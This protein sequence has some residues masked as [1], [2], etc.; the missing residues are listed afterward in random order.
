[1]YSDKEKILL[2]SNMYPSTKYPHYGIFVQ[3]T[4]EVL[5][6][7]GMTVDVVAM[8]KQD[9]AVKKLLAYL[10]FYSSVIYRG[11]I[12]KY[13]TVYAHYASHT[14]LPLLILS[15]LKTVKIVVNVHGNDVVSQCKKDEKFLFLVQ[16]LL[17]KA[18]AVICPSAYFQE[19][20]EREFSVPKGNTLVYPSGGVNTDLFRKIPKSQ[21]AQHFGLNET[22]QYIG[23]VSRIEE[24]KGWDIFLKM[25]AQLRQE[26]P[27]IKFLVVGDGDQAAN[28]HQL[29]QS[30][31]LTDAIIKFNLLSQQELAY[32]YNLLDVFVFPT[33]RKS[34]SLGLVG[35]EAM[36]CE[37]V[38]VL[39]DSYGPASY[40]RDGENAFV[41]KAGD[42]HSLYDAV[43]RALQG[44]HPDIRTG[45]RKTALQYNP[46]HTDPVLIN[47][48]RELHTKC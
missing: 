12:G 7:A 32:I 8:R 3:H 48:F 34:E 45:A 19:I 28:F 37:T 36:A 2:V 44:V 35:L 43:E 46:K 31:G 11:L 15:K 30:L 23:Y 14:A 42:V 18:D 29:A 25:A 17:S 41:F 22:D 5:R 1:M 27:G 24:K 10:Q 20:V 39:P 26:Y 16:K 6:S 47:F 40:G 21:A 9:G 13:G 38:T 33:Y 4:A